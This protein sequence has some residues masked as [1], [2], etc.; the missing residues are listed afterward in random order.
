MPLLNIQMN[1]REVGRIRTGDRTQTAKGTAPRKLD[2]FRFTSDDAQLLGLVADRYGGSVEAWDDQWQV[3]ATAERIPVMIVPHLRPITQWWEAWTG[4]GCTRRCDGNWE[5][6]ANTQC[7][8]AVNDDRICKPT[9]R[10][11][12]VL[13]EIPGLGTWRLETHGYYAAVELGGTLELI[14][15]L[16]LAT[17]DPVYGQ[18]RL[19]Q[20]S[21]QTPGQP[22]R[23]FAVPTVDV[24]VTVPQLAAQVAAAAPT[25]IDGANSARLQALAAAAPVGASRAFPDEADREAAE[26]RGQAKLGR[27]RTP[28]MGPGRRGK[29]V[30]PEPE[31]A[32]VVA[33]VDVQDAD[34]FQI[35]TLADEATHHEVQQAFA[36][37]LSAQQLKALQTLMRMTGLDDRDERLLFSARIIGRSIS[38]SKDL[39]SAEASQIIEVLAAVE[40]GTAQYVTDA[41]GAI[42]GAVPVDTDSADIFHSDPVPHPDDLEPQ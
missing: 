37:P 30:P 13:H 16:A 23:R 3:Y 15:Q 1:L 7:P 18:L 27:K 19:T 33:A 14:T 29:I 10:L 36:S 24:N 35:T 22:T 8:C 11:Q 31:S 26:Q 2:H 17:G 21:Q 32:D 28:D 20:R 39:T 12:L 41:Y 5:L 42:V 25:A 34:R 40:Q 4:G 6:I 9:T 38:S